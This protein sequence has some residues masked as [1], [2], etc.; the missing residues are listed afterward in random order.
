MAFLDLFKA[1]YEKFEMPL[2]H[3]ERKNSNLVWLQMSHDVISLK[4]L[5]E[6]NR[7]FNKNPSQVNSKM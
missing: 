6:F 5:L 2:N 4:K 1:Q 7:N 3:Q